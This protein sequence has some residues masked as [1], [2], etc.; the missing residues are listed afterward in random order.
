[1]LC[2]ETAAKKGALDTLFAAVFERADGL[3][4]IEERPEGAVDATGLESRYASAHYVNRR[5]ES[6]AFVQ[7]HWPKFTV[8][9]H[10]KTYL[11]AGAVMSCGPSND[12]AFFKPAMT[13]AAGH[14]AFDR[15]LADK[16]YDAEYA[17][18][19]AETNWESVPPSFH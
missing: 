2:G 16:G 6:R 13:Q 19:G 18:N 14:I 17:H 12:V 15:I 4:L 9:C 3:G 7:R 1:M 5:N 10:V 8:V 11:F